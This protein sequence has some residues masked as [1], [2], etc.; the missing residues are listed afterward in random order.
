MGGPLYPTPLPANFLTIQAWLSVRCEQPQV[1]PTLCGIPPTL[2][3]NPFMKS[4]SKPPILNVASERL[5]PAET[6]MDS[7]QKSSVFCYL[8]FSLDQYILLLS[9]SKYSWL[10]RARWAGGGLLKWS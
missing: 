6:L 5:F 8:V 7:F 3:N 4:S 9:I 1:I 2:L 10:H